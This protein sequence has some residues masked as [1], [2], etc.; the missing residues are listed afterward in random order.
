MYKRNKAAENTADDLERETA[1]WS[2]GPGN[3]FSVLLHGN[4]VTL[5]F[6]L[7]L[8]KTSFL[9]LSHLSSSSVMFSAALLPLSK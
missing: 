8:Q 4:A 2:C 3:I 1:C 7:L 6:A 9:S 5:N